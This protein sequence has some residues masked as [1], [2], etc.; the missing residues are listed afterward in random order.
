MAQNSPENPSAVT[1]PNFSY[2]VKLLFL[3]GFRWAFRGLRGWRKGVE[4]C[5]HTRLLLRPLASA[6]VLVWIWPI[7]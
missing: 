2:M 7:S 6:V 5:E 4:G 3:K 1:S